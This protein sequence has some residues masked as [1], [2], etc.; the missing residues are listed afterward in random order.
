M[1]FIRQVLLVMIGVLIVGGSLSA[2]TVEVWPG[3]Y[4]ITNKNI[5]HAIET[6]GLA[7]I[8][9]KDDDTLILFPN[10]Y[11]KRFIELN[12]LNI[13][14]VSIDQSEKLISNV[15]EYEKKYESNKDAL[16]P[17]KWAFDILSKSIGNSKVIS[18]MGNIYVFKEMM[19]GMIGNTV[20]IIYK[21]LKEGKFNK[22]EI[23]AKMIEYSRIRRQPQSHPLS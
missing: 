20:D 15:K 7:S 8:I 13:S 12:L 4:N 1:K 22:R 18:D 17:V 2:R 19:N 9:K 6:N 10:E 3:L 14:T 21:S 5:L 11:N 16:D 23:T